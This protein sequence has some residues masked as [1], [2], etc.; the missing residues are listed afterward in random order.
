M[1]TLPSR[2]TY[3]AG[4]V[5]SPATNWNANAPDVVALA[6]VARG[7]GG[8][9]RRFVHNCERTGTKRSKDGE[10]AANAEDLFEHGNL[11][12]IVRCR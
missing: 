2:F 10:R 3:T 12:E 6:V 7:L 1:S 8:G 9:G 11:P 4:R 5:S